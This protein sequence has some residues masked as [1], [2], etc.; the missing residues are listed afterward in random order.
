M[1]P[2]D[3]PLPRFVAE[4]PKEL[5]PYGRWAE[6]LSE[7][8]VEAVEA[9]ELD[10]APAQP[11]SIAWFPERTYAGRTYV[12]AVAPLARGGEL[13][14]YVSFR[15]PQQSSDPEITSEAASEAASQA[16]DQ[17]LEPTDFIAR[18]DYTDETAD[19]N[20]HWKLDLNEDVIARWRGPGTAGGDLALVW[21]SP[22]VANGTVVTAELGEETLDQCALVQNDRF[23]LVALDAVTGFGADL[24]LEVKLWSKAGE[25]LAL[26]T[27]YEEGD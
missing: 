21:G 4:P 16:G 3:R 18:A 7:R 23:T 19:Q 26:E 22:L 9:I 11:E 17:E 25:L 20:P 27:L 5:Q 10:P 14:G 12:P 1:P 15:R 6:L 24:Y 8:F 13:F 2:T